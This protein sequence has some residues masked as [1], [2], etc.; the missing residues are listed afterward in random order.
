MIG[1]GEMFGL[2]KIPEMSAILKFTVF[3]YHISIFDG[4]PQIEILILL[5]WLGGMAQWAS[6]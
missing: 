4:G 5:M 2:A 3:K 1:T 6:T